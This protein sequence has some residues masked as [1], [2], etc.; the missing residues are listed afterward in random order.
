MSGDRDRE[1]VGVVL[2]SQDATPLEFWIGG[3]ADR[4]S[5]VASKRAYATFLLYSV[6]RSGGLGLDAANA[7]ALVSNVKGEDLLWL[8]RP[9]ARLD[10]R[11]R[12][13]YRRLG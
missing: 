8:D 12:D 11:P 9:N 5:G 3:H 2:G 13:E 7:K 6:F 10:E 4:I 1:T